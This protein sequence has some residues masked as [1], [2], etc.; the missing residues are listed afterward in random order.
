MV[1]VR[2]FSFLLAGSALVAGQMHQVPVVELYTDNQG[3]YFPAGRT[4]YAVAFDDGRLDYMDTA[5]HDLVV[6]HRM[7]TAAELAVLQEQI[8]H[9]S[10]LQSTASIDADHQ[11]KRADYQTILEISIRRDR[12]TQRF[13]L[14]GFD[15]EDG[16]PFPQAVNA[17]LC[18]V[19]DLKGVQYRLSSMCPTTR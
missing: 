2:L 15:A 4:L 9:K 10:L 14:R 12:T 13:V 7:L 5:N 1:I 18:V 6:K 11:P 16:R 3:L 17:L 19:D 8:A